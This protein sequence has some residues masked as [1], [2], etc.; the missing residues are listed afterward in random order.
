MD[1]A[2]LDGNP[3]QGLVDL[4][5][6]Q[7]NQRRLGISLF[8]TKE[9][10]AIAEHGRNQPKSSLK[11]RFSAGP[12]YSRIFKPDSI[13]VDNYL[14]ICSRN[15]ESRRRKLQTIMITNCILLAKDYLTAWSWWQRNVYIYCSTDF[16]IRPWLLLVPHSD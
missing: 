10:L 12:G 11:L 13:K 14:W 7:Q 16:H 2:Y 1:S 8:G 3:S 4:M 9:L 15:T 6:W 5:I